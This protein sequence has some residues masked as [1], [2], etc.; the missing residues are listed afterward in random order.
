MHLNKIISGLSYSLKIVSV[1]WKEVGNTLFQK[2][3]EGIFVKLSGL[4]EHSTQMVW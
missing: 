3:K 4:K 2:Y 1:I